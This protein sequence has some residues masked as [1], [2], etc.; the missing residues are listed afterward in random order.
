MTQVLDFLMGIWDYFAANILTQPAFL[1]GFIVLL[2]YVLLKKPLYESIAGFL[3]ATV[4]YLIL[5]VGSGGLVNNFRPILVGLKERFNL[6]A[7]VI[8]PYF[9]QNAVTAGIEETFGRTFS[10]TMILLLI[11][12]VMN[13]LLV[14]F[15]KYTKLRAV[16]T[17]GNVQIQQAATAFWILLFC[18]PNLG[19]IQILLIMG[20]ILGCYWAVGSNLT[21]DIT[22]DLTEGAGF[23]IAHQQMF[24]V[25]IFARLAEKMKKDKNNRKLEDV[26]LPGFLS[27]FN[28]NMVATSILMLFF[29]GI[30]LVVLGPAY[31]I[32]AGFMVEGQSFFFYILQTALYFAVYLA[33]LQLGVR[34]FVS[35][36]T[37]SF[38]GI[39]NTLL[40]GAVPGI[41]VAATFGFGSP[42]AVTIGFLFGALGQ[43]ITIGLLILFK[44]P[45][46]V[47]AGF[48]PLFFDNAVIA[49][50][51]NNR[52]GFKAAC[53]FPFISGVIQVLGS[54]LIAAFIGL[55]QYGGYIGMF[56]W[57][58][59][60]PVMTL[61]MKYLGYFGVAL[62]VI[63]LLAIPQLQY[64]ANP[65]GYFLIAEDYDEYV[66]KMAAKGA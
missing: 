25:Y 31:L 26:Q 51:A 40:P 60:W 30:I 49:V 54:A 17:T 20:L 36:L 59:V 10:D 61:L 50:Y 13:I 64:R 48:I 41:D 55:S 3:K 43:F 22:Q 11:A 53:I 63:I 18:F 5:T 21:V 44:S 57:A 12:F 37:E 56:D 14:R 27:I 32:D 65:E 47:I 66:K 34:T 38:Q 28:E 39:S 62:V 15:K 29:F 6:D 35:E 24:G 52:G 58:T 23:A 19:Q 46:I 7:M 2:G 4:G 42:N 9:G 16:F 1:I 8:D 33:I 45:V